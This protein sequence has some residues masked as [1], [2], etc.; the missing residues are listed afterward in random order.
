MSALPPDDDRTRMLA[1]SAADDPTMPELPAGTANALPPGTRL[2]EFELTGVIGVGGFGIVYLAYDHSLERQVAIKEYMPASLAARSN[3]A[4]VSVKSAR[5]ADTFQAGMRSFINEARLLARFDHPAL[6]KVYRFWEGNGTAYMVMPYY[7]GQTLTQAVRE[8]ASPPDEAWLRALLAPLLDALETI[9]AEQCFHRDIAPDNILMLANDRPLLLDF[10]AARRAIAGMAQNFTVILKPGY[11]PIEQYAEVASMQ[12]GPWTDIYALASVVHFAITG[13]PPAPSVARMIADPQ[14]PLARSAA[15]R[16]SDA[17]LRVIDQALAVR[18]EQ[19]PQ[20]IAELRA[21]LGLPS[22]L[23]RQRQPDVVAAAKAGPTKAEPLRTATPPPP[24]AGGQP[25]AAEAG[26]SLMRYA[27]AGALLVLAAGAT[28]V[29]R[30]THDHVQ[31]DR[32]KVSPAP[33]APP[34]Q[35][36]MPASAPPI[37]PPVAAAAADPIA[38][39]E[40]IVQASNR[41]HAVTVAVQQPQVR[42]GKD[43][44]RFSVRSSKPGYVYVLMV[45]TDHSQFWLLFPNEVDRNNRIGANRTLELPRPSWRMTAAGPA[46]TDH[47]VA[48]VSEAPRDFSAAGLKAS[49]PFAEFPM[50]ALARAAPAAAGVSIFSGTP[51]CAPGAGTTCPTSYGAAL[52]SIEETAPD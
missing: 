51:R 49:P 50:A 33:A 1:P 35:S 6:L 45:G 12:Q 17:F 42:I 52:F 20:S 38:V 23:A 39:L 24:P 4:H 28:I 8:M 7:Q 40:Q 29:Y 34:V 43:R 31:A 18:P 47:M 37:A 5:H 41:D 27:V 22:A 15:G 32:E 10:G 16:Y 44:L 25:E 13:R 46:G 26:N 36:R 48:V 3:L 30:V 21:L 2:G 14:E 9:H 11:A 19:R